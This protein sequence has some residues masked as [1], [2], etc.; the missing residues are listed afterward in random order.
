MPSATEDLEGSLN[1]AEA[2]VE[3]CVDEG[4]PTRSWKD[5]FVCVCVCVC[6]CVHEA[7]LDVLRLSFVFQRP[8]GTE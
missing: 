3:G 7:D 5:P 1:Y 6:V 4:S 8:E 2:C